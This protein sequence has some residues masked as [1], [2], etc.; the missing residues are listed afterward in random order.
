MLKRLHKNQRGKKKKKKPALIGGHL[1]HDPWIN[2]ACVQTA[3]LPV[4]IGLSVNNHF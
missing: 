2:I 1:Q 3:G 4:N